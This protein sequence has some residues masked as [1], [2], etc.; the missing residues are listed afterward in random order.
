MPKYYSW[1][2]GVIDQSGIVRDRSGMNRRQTGKFTG[3]IL[4]PNERGFAKP[5]GPPLGLIFVDDA[6]LRFR[7][8]V[9][10]KANGEVKILEYSYHYQRPNGYYFRYDKLK[11]PFTDPIKQ[12]VEPQRHLQVSQP[13]PRFPTHATH[14]IEVLALLKHNFYS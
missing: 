12:I 9:V 4:A 2:L 3:R 7:E 14:L 6:Y 13:A 1:L 5:G 11:T 8:E 10:I